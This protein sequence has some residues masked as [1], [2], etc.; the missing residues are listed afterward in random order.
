MVISSR[1]LSYRV[2]Q[3]LHRAKALGKETK[4][5]S[6]LA[7]TLKE[8][9][10]RDSD[11]TPS[12]VT[13]DSSKSTSFVNHR[14]IYPEFLPDPN[15]LYRNNVREK[16]ERMDMVARRS[17]ISIPQFYVGS[18]LSVTYSEPH[19]AGK[20]N[21]FVG[22]CISREGAGLRAAFILR[23]AVNGEGVEVKYHLYDPA[24]QKIVCLRLEKRLDN[25]LFYLRDAPI[26]YSTFPFDMEPELE[27]EGTTVPVNE[28]KIPLNKP[29]W[30]ERWERKELKGV[31]K[32]SIVVNE[33]RLRKAEAA[34]KP[35]EKYDLMKIY[36][37]TIPEEEQNEIFCD[38]HT[39]LSQLEV[40]KSILKRKR[41]FVRPKKVV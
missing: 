6:S 12:R 39:E 8:D 31:I 5:F 38:V 20:V 10:K 35:W 2:W 23:N 24:I 19:A 37:E 21:T 26:E 17:V 11:E 25:E 34:R 28:L 14:F 9:I 33:K 30:L 7:E 13:Q 40:K 16:L 41:T 22:I 32:E 18:I 36:R 15:S 27:S 3:N 4:A 29:P 1:L